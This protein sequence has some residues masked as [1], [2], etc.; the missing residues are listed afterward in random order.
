MTPERP[1]TSPASSSD[2]QA[3]V[4]DEQRNAPSSP[5]ISFD[6][7]PESD[8]SASSSSLLSSG[9]G[10]DSEPVVA[11]KPRPAVRSWPA[12][13]EIALLEAV[14]SHRQSHG[15]FPSPDDLFAALRGRLHGDRADGPEQVA[16]RLHA[17]QVRYGKAAAR[18]ARGIIPA[19]DD[20]VTIYRLSKLLWAGGRRG[21]GQRKDRAADAR[22]E[23]RGFS[24]LAQL[25]PCLA[26]EV[27]AIDAECGATPMALRAFGR[28]GDDTAARLEAKVKKQWVAEARA[29]TERDRLRRNVANTLLG[30]IK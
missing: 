12:S 7:A 26:A 20:D 15:R 24:E 23:P 10:S 2:T 28:I 25:Y 4:S 14:A 22:K 17:L 18:L 8:A 29:S 27:E 1:S 5:S 21:K 6:S 19:K 30:L 13:E 16:R 3:T 9:S 11:R